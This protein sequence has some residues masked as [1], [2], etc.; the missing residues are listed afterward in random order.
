MRLMPE[1][2]D[3]CSCEDLLMW[4]FHVTWLLDST[5]ALRQLEV[6]FSGTLRIQL[7]PIITG[8]EAKL[9]T[10]PLSSLKSYTPTQAREEG[11]DALSVGGWQ[12]SP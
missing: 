4:P 2:R 5:A 10:H 12:R 7:S 6:V 1:G 3:C 9:H 11:G 8:L